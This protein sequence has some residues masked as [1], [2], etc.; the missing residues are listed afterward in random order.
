MQNLS[1]DAPFCSDS[2]ARLGGLHKGSACKVCRRPTPRCKEGELTLE[3][4]RQVA[5][6]GR[7]RPRLGWSSEQGRAGL[8][9]AG[10]EQEREAAL[11]RTRGRTSLRVAQGISLH[12]HGGSPLCVAPRAASRGR[13][14]WDHH[15]PQVHIRDSMARHT[16][17][18]ESLCAA[19]SEQVR[20][21]L[22]D[23][24]AV[25]A[26]HTPKTRKR[27][28]P[29]LTART[30]HAPR[31]GAGRA[32]PEVFS[33]RRRFLP[34][35]QQPRAPAAGVF[36][37]GSDSGFRRGL[38]VR[39]R[40]PTEPLQGP[41]RSWEAQQERSALLPPRPTSVSPPSLPQPW[42]SSGFTS[43]GVPGLALASRPA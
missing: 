28:P 7:A 4:E 33:S 2:R 29:G 12:S 39:A 34:V 10:G 41:A 11:G 43:K 30:A 38:V 6:A 23:L 22:R 18:A 14:L 31:E 35:W 40:D 42:V 3:T 36:L 21:R 13:S 37:H 1:P 9:G 16:G 20:Q 15:L 24:A 5:R 19:G 26:A 17:F 25:P 32:L 27:A 8:H